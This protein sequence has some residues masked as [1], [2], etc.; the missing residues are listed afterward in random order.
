[1]IDAEEINGLQE[2][3]YVTTNVTALTEDMVMAINVL[4]SVKEPTAKEMATLLDGYA[5]LFRKMDIDI[6]K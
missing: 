2:E 6:I 1:M 5:D 3:E 4:F